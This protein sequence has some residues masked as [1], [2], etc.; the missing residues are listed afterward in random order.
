MYGERDPLPVDLQIGYSK[1]LEHLPFRFSIIG[2]HL[3]DPYIRFDDPEV[4]VTTDIFG[5]ETYKS[6]FS[7]NVDN[8]F[9]HII[10]NG[11][12]LIG[13]NEG[14]RLRVGYDHLR[15][16]E[17]KATT[18]R[19]L[20]GFSMGFGFSIRRFKFDYGVGHYHLVGAANHLSLR[21][22]IGRFFKKI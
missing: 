3:F 5:V 13:K 21:Y 4:D 10:F 15:R 11:E 19:S 7:K 1:R 8:F 14:F 6:S 16:Q 12:F 22:D 20:G 2:H 17:L 9:R 18:F